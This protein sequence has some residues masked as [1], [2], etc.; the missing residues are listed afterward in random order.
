M[1]IEEEDQREGKKVK[2]GGVAKQNIEAGLSVQP[3]KDQ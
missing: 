3:C 1:E 2:G